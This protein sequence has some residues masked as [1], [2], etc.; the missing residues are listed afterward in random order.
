[1]GAIPP[2]SLTKRINVLFIFF[3]FLGLFISSRYANLSVF[4]HRF[5]A[6]TPLLSALNDPS[7]N[8][9]RGEIFFKDRFSELMPLAINKDFFTVYADTRLVKEKEAAARTLF[10]LLSVPYD[11]LFEKL[12]KPD[13]PY[14]ALAQKVPDAIVDE[15]RDLRMPGIGI[16]AQKGRYYPYQNSASHVVGFLGIKNDK[17]TG[18][19]GLESFYEDDIRDGGMSS[20]LVLSVDPHIQFKLEEALKE[21]IQKWQARFGTAIV[22][23]PSTGRMLGMA[24]YPD[25]NPNEYAKVS[26]ISVFNN[27]AIAG[28]FEL[29]SVFKPI[30]MAAGLNEKVITPET[31]YEDKGQVTMGSYVIKNWDGKVHGVK[32][33]T[34]VLENSLNTGVVFVEEKIPKETFGKY[35]R[36]FGFGAKTGIDLSGEVSGNTR[37]LNTNRDFEFANISF[38]QGIAITP[39][40]MTSALAAVAN[41]G[42]L[43]KPHVVDHVFFADGSD[44]IIQPEPVRSV[45]SR[46]TAQALTKMLVSTVVN[47]NDK[48]RVPGYFVAGKTGTAQIPNEDKKGYSEN[49]IHSFAGFAPAYHPQ[50]VLFL[51]I[52]SPQG[53]RFASES[54]APAFADIM[55]YLLTYYEIP[56][57]FK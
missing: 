4:H 10:A 27:T 5:G 39:L 1:M 2:Y 35:I 24:N 26:D 18:Q 14:E 31:T 37:N 54:L 51:S 41:N 55:S 34:E 30:T 46:E 45:V 19:Y 52:D 17:K 8:Q 11:A 29:G 57:D 22:L 9:Q 33:M 20:R 48:A 42:V 25:F 38:G 13:D 47:G 6:T 16:E 15:I 43:M 21:T 3:L 23:E 49:T 50:F 32:T 40:Q 36:E 56:P 7:V 28:Q 44:A 12:S 53:V